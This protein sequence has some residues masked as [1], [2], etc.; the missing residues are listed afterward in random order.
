MP[1]FESFS[2]V[3]VPFPFTDQDT[4]KKRPALVLSGSLFNTSVGHSVLAMITSAKNSTWLYDVHISDLKSAG[5]SSASIV[6]MKLFT[7]DNRLIIRKAG[8]L[9]NSD[10]QAVTKAFSKL[11]DINT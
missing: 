11:F 4:A 2:I 10:Q 6:R 9:A 3:V 1:T 7:L 5:L 8:I